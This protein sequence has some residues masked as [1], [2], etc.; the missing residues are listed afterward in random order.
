MKSTSRS[1]SEVNR[2]RVKALTKLLGSDFKEA[3]EVGVRQYLQT[4]LLQIAQSLMAGE[5]MELC[6]EEYERDPKR[7]FTRHGYQKGVIA[8]PDGSKTAIER[9]RARNVKSRSEAVLET[10]NAFADKAFLDERT[11]ALIGAGVSE[12]ALKRVLEKGLDRKGVSRSAVSRRVIRS[13]LDSLKV[14][15]ERTWDKVRFVALLFDGV[16]V[17]NRMVVACVGIDLSGRKHV[18]GIQPGATENAIVCRDLIRK[19]VDRGLDVD[20]N[21]LFVLDGSKALRAAIVERFGKEVI[22]QRCQEHKIRD[23]EAYLPVK[24]RHKFRLRIQGA[25]NTR[26]Y[27]EA[28]KRLQAIRSDLSLLSE[29]AVRSFIEGLEDTLTLHKLGIWGGLRDSLKTTNIIESAFSTLRRKTSNVTSWQ[30]EPQI[31]RWMAHG[32]MAAEQRFK[33]VPGHRTLTR[34]RKALEHCYSAQQVL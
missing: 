13:T 4:L 17:G 26:S 7:T 23:V 30:D 9:P 19:L 25:Y 15:E 16:S 21:Y 12:R 29:Q 22:V 31:N 27:R 11:L 1:N 3:I 33:R 18:L 34:L 2:H 5:I 8:L 14:F 6:G 32:L 28:S 20:G 24:D 10:Y